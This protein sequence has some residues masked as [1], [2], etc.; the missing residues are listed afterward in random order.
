LTIKPHTI[1]IVAAD[2]AGTGY[3]KLNEARR[4]FWGRRHACLQDPDGNRVDLFSSIADRG[5]E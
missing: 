1:D 5:Q 4:A 3:A 2:M